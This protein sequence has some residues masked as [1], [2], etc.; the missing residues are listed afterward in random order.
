ALAGREMRYRAWGRPSTPRDDQ[1]A[2]ARPDARG[3]IE[4]RDS[5]RGA[6]ITWSARRPWSPQPGRDRRAVARSLRL[7]APTRLPLASR[8][9]PRHYGGALRACRAPAR[10]HRWLETRRRGIE[11]APTRC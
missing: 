7:A 6:A 11:I 4:Y 1:L 2:R 9:G 10:R 8:Q 3:E 5:A